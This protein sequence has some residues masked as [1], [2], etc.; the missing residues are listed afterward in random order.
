VLQRGL[1]QLQRSEHHN[2]QG[3]STAQ[4]QWIRHPPSSNQ[5]GDNAVSPTHTRYP[6][7]SNVYLGTSSQTHTSASEYF[8]NCFS[9][10]ALNKYSRQH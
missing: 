2:M 8:H 5:D 3:S 6:P 4:H 9:N 1:Q 7:H 10:R